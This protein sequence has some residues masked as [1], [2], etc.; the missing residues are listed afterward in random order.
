M[1]LNSKDTVPM[2]SLSKVRI[3][4]ERPPAGTPVAVARGVEL[5]GIV[6]IVLDG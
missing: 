2:E 3:A 5:P 6:T 4:V 1:R